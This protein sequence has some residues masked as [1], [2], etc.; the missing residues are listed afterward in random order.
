M[1]GETRMRKWVT[2]SLILALL[3]TVAGLSV[4]AADDSWTC[5]ACGKPNYGGSAC[6]SCGTSREPPESVANE[7]WP[8][9]NLKWQEMIVQ[10]LPDPSQ[11]LWP[12]IAPGKYA[13]GS[14]VYNHRKVTAKALFIE[15]GHYV[16]TDMTFNRSLHKVVY[17]NRSTFNKNSQALLPEV[18]LNKNVK[19]RIVSDLVPSYGPGDQYEI[20]K[21]GVNE[22]QV[23]AGELVTVLFEMDG[24][25]FID[26]DSSLGET[27]G[28]I[29]VD[30]AAAP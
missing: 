29:P 27:R 3:T 6:A 2:L 7:Q 26:F 8:Q 22:I 10:K 30:M 5:E 24:Y 20:L 28:W 12:K 17:L 9:M 25:L 19:G 15:D 1:E 16:L 11:N 13:H 4:A 14:G 23:K 18:E 21:D